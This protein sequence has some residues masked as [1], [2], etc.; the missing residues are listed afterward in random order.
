MVDIY[1]LGHSCFRIKGKQ[2]SVVIDPFND[3]VGIKFPREVSADILLCTHD[4][5]DHNNIGA[6]VGNPLLIQGP[7]EYEIKSVAIC[8]IQTYH[9]QVKGAKRG[10]NTVY[11]FTIDGI[12]F[13]HLGDL[14]MKLTECQI[15]ELD[16]VDILMV[17][18]GGETTID[19]KTASETI[20]EIEP[21]IIL[22]MHYKTDKHK[23]QEEDFKQ[24]EN[25]IK[26]SGFEPQK[27]SGKLSIAK[28]KLPEQ[29]TLYVFE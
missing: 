13:A 3:E 11:R 6:I 21:S 24:I 17:P 23:N 8:G 29:T 10:I 2:V 5:F 22:P 25:F 15:E 27:L 9:D 19:A 28:D 20:A 16:G 4:H 7:G 18:V 12:T 1:Y 26:T 14:G